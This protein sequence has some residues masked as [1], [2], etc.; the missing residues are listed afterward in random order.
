MPIYEYE[1]DRC[2]CRFEQRQ[3]ISDDPVRVCPKCA[4]TVRRL[5]QLVGVVFKASGFYITDN[6]PKP[7]DD[8]G[9][10]KTT[11]VTPT[12]TNKQQD[13]SGPPAGLQG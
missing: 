2:A 11:E 5:I 1:C 4:G 9:E 8:G 13:E 10:K 12:K 7:S 3:S 6:R